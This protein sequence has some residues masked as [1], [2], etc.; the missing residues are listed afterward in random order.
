MKKIIGTALVALALVGSASSAFANSGY[1]GPTKQSEL[2][3]QLEFWNQFK[4]G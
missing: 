3:R 4:G 1:Q 2:A